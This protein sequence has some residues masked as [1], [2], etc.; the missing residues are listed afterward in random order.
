MVG[1]PRIIIASDLYNLISR[2]FYK[3]KGEKPAGIFYNIIGLYYLTK[4]IYSKSYIRT[5]T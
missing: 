3:M 2:T 1:R 4:V 5:F